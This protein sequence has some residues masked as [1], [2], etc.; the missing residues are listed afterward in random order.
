MYKRNSIP[1]DS[2]FGMYEVKFEKFEYEKINIEKSD[3][4][5]LDNTF[6]TLNQIPFSNR[7]IR[8]EAGEDSKNIL[9]AGNVLKQMADL[10]LNKDSKIHAVG[11]GTIQDL[12]TFVASTYMRGISW[13][14]YPTTLQA[15][16]DSCIGGKSAI[17]VGG[18]K[19]IIGNFHPP[20]AVIVDA[21]LVETLSPEDVTCGL[22]EAV[23]IVFAFGGDNVDIMLDLIDSDEVL[24]NRSFDSHETI[25]DLSLQSKKYFVEVDEFD[26]SVRRKLNFGHTYGHVIEAA[27]DYRI[28]HGL[29]VGLGILASFVHRDSQVILPSE[30]KLISVVR[31]LLRPYKS[32]LIEEV[33]SIS[34]SDFSHYIQLDKKVTNSTLRFIHSISGALEV[35]SLPNSEVTYHAALECILEATYG[36]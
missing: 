27:T 18:Y 35:V 30:E 15:M 1:I 23:K 7:T 24:T 21:I 11:G 16:V 14:F 6:G 5:I 8:I 22:L 10:G 4:V 31:K 32:S 36:I 28:H 9:M 26:K 13:D 33:S 2:S 3:L 17:N 19:N 25:I 12:A 29:A 34:R 20:R